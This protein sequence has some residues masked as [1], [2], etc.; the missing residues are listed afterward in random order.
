MNLG[1]KPYSLVCKLPSKTNEGR[2]CHTLFELEHTPNMKNIINILM[3][4]YLVDLMLYWS[5]ILHI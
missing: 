2:Q 4:I 3:A 5:I 1:D